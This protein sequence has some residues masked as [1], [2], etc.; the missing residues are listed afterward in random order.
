MK[1]C[2]SFASS[3]LPLSQKLEP[4]K[5]PVRFSSD[6]RHDIMLLGRLENGF[7]RFD[8]YI[9]SF[10]ARLRDGCSMA[11]TSTPSE[12]LRSS[13]KAGGAITI[14]QAACLTRLQA[15]ST[16]GERARLRR[17]AGCATSTGFAGHAGAAPNLKLHSTRTTQWGQSGW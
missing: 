10:N 5:I 15:T 9:E 7:D 8:G 13:S 14:R 17:V 2:G 16:R 12:K 6:V 4:S 1:T 11:R 3:W